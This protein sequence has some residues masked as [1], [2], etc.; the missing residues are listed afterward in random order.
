VELTGVFLVGP[1]FW[2]GF[3]VSFVVLVADLVYLRRHAVAAARRRHAR[4]SRLAWVAA[5][6]AVI[7]REQER[8]AEQ[9][10]AERADVARQSAG[11]RLDA[12]RLAMPHTER[13]PRR[14]G[15]D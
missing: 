1:G 12:R 11:S 4:R 5:E 6:Q 13:H 10:L 9:R 3:S 15:T 14:T 8:R 7:R 2:I